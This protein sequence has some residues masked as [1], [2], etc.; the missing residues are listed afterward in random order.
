MLFNKSYI[1]F[2][3]KEFQKKYKDLIKNKIIFNNEVL[4]AEHINKF[5]FNMENWWDL[6]E[7]KKVL[8]NFNSNL[9]VIGEK[10]SLDILKSKLVDL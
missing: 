5:W 2:I 3:T 1:N 8:K 10:Q 9:N 7:T 4:L 6:K